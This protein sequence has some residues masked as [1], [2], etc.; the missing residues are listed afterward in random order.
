MESVFETRINNLIDCIDNNFMVLDDDILSPFEL[1]FKY[2]W[3]KAKER[4]ANGSNEN[5]VGRPGY[6]ESSEQTR[7]GNCD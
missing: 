4:Y 1:G 6:S 5:T 3:I 7:P 2:G